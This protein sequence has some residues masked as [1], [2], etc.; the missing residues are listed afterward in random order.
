MF[1]VRDSSEKAMF[2]FFSTAFSEH[3]L[4][5][6]LNFNK[7]FSTSKYLAVTGFNLNFATDN[8]IQA[9]IKNGKIGNER[10]PKP[11]FASHCR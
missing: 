3:I 2:P 8:T 1:I 9:K 6:G 5:H 11:S 4:I 10:M 7:F